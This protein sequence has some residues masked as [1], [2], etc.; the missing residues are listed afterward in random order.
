M[1]YYF[2]FQCLFLNIL[3]ILISFNLKYLML[4]H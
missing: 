3:G 1:Y 4:E 2:K